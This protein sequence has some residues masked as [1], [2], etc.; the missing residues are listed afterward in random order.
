MPATYLIA[1]RD[2]TIETAVGYWVDGNTLH[3]IRRGN[4][5]QAVSLDQVDL[6]RT[7]ELNR[8][9]RGEFRLR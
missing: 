4:E 7:E 5:H 6:P 1:L 3:F 9:R 2:G 8:A